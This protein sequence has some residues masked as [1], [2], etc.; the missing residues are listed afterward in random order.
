MKLNWMRVCV[1]QH[2]FRKKISFCSILNYRIGLF[3]LVFFLDEI[4]VRS[5][6]CPFEMPTS[7]PAAH[8]PAFTR[9]INE[10]TKL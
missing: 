5:R 6:C 4:N 9:L 3:A 2:T 7:R 8:L 10:H 1:R